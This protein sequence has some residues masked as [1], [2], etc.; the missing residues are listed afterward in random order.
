MR[1]GGASE[2]DDI[3]WAWQG[4]PFALGPKPAGRYRAFLPISQAGIKASMN[5][6]VTTM[7]QSRNP[8]V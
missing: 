6:T 7:K 8:R 3:F 5:T 2:C 4:A 1:G